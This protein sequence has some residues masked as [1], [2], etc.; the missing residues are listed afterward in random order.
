MARSPY[1]KRL[2]DPSSPWL[3]RALQLFSAAAISLSIAVQLGL[4]NPFWAA[5]PVWVVAQPFRQDLFLRAILRIGGTAV[6]AA[7]G[8]SAL[9]LLPDPAARVLVISV[10]VGAG[11]AATYWIGSVYSYGVLMAAITAVV[12]LVPAMDHP[13]NAGALALDRIW[14]TMIGVV[15]VTLITFAFT[16]R[17]TASAPILLKPMPRVTLRHGVLAGLTA[18]LGGVILMAVGGPLGMGAALAL[19]IFS[20]IIGSSRNPIPILRYLP[21]GATI[22]VIAAILYRWLDV[23][24]TDPV[25]MA[26]LLALPFI[27]AGALMRAHPRT[28]PFGLDANMCF[29]LAAE[30]GAAGHGLTVH[31]QGGLALITAAFGFVA[32][33]HIVGDKG[34]GT[35]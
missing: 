30:A 12:V 28:A 14:C 6:G 26:L 15:V 19:C 34:Q 29:L 21:L 1:V 16:P 31:I 8:W 25:G 7:V 23:S 33:F 32:L 5:M 17:R 4:Q 10:V 3:F 9:M 2:M 13:V 35:S 18:L 22:G 20:L 11:A 27:G 24:L